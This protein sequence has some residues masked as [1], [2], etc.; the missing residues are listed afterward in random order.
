MV[1]ELRKLV[2]VMAIRR[3][4]LRGVKRQSVGYE[5]PE[6]KLV[7]SGSFE[8]QIDDKPGCVGC[9]GCEKGTDVGDSFGSGCLFYL[10]GWRFWGFKGTR[11]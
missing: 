3:L 5:G 11:H 8:S 4:R 2:V 1:G 10:E 9:V 6:V 7:P